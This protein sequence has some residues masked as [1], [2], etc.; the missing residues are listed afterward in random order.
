[1][2]QPKMSLKTQRIT[3]K[4]ALYWYENSILEC[5]VTNLNIT[6][7]LGKC[8]SNLRQFL[9]KEGP[10]AGRRG[11]HSLWHIWHQGWVMLLPT[12]HGRFWFPW[13]IFWFSQPQWGLLPVASPSF[14]YLFKQKTKKQL[15][16]SHGPNHYKH[17]L[18][19]FAADFI[20]ASRSRAKPT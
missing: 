6:A 19:S 1:M 15:S 5:F 3:W 17:F 9:C 16:V 7:I 11:W 10:A 18:E 2:A 12:L 8:G 13:A 4:T 20:I 14:K